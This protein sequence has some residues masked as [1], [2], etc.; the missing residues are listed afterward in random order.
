MV[1]F[2]QS[3]PHPSPL[4]P[5]AGGEGALQEFLLYPLSPNGG[6]GQGE[7]ELDHGS[8]PVNKYVTEFITHC[9]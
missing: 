8:V 2:L 5:P 6:E 3:P 7:G 1:T 4:P 9:T